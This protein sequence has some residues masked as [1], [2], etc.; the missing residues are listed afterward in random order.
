MKLLSTQYAMKDFQKDFNLKIRKQATEKE[1]FKTLKLELIDHL[2]NFNVDLKAFKNLRIYMEGYSLCMTYTEIT[3]QPIFFRFI[4]KIIEIDVEKIN[5]LNQSFSKEI[6][7]PVYPTI[8]ITDSFT[9]ANYGL[10]YPD[11]QNILISKHFIEQHKWPLISQVIK[12]EIL[13]HLC[14]VKGLPA[15]DT[16]EHFVRLLIKYGAFISLEENAQRVYK[17]VLVKMVS[18]KAVRSGVMNTMELGS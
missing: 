2:K 12:H 7:A 13:H 18:E 11:E 14:T 5:K 1:K 6:A 16:D 10:Y 17:E 8:T 9:H 3:D 15:N 4:W